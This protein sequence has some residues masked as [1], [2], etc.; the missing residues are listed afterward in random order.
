MNKH[1]QLSRRNAG[2]WGAICGSLLIG[3]PLS[4]LPGVAKPIAQMNE[5]PCTCPAAPG[6]R[7]STPGTTQSTVINSRPSI[8]N[9]PPYNRVL[10]VP[11]AGGPLP[12]APYTPNRIVPADA[13]TTPA[14]IAPT[15]GQPGIAVYGNPPG[16]TN[17]PGTALTAPV[18]PPLPEERSTPIATVTPMD[19]KVDV[20]LKNATNAIITYD[21]IGYTQR[22]VLPG[23][24]E[25][26]LRDLPLPVTITT[27]RQDGGLVDVLP[28]STTETGLLE[29]TLNESKDLDDNAGVLRIQQNGQVFLN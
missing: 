6:N 9:E 23:G 13:P 22:R 18:K 27:V 11:Q 14:Q 2:L 20:K 16:V 15:P 19:G 29:V 17:P 24:E 4:P 8:F 28:L 7:V 5:N 1:N 25:V 26:V 10:S 21:A 12:G 3:V